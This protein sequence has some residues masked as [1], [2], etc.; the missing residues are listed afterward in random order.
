MK[1]W[2]ALVM[3]LLAACDRAV[4]PAARSSDAVT[5]PRQVE[6]V[7]AL[8]Q[9]ISVTEQLPAELAPW[10]VVAVYPKV[11]GFVANIPVDRGS[12]VRRGELLVKLS[13]PELVA[14]TA[15]A[16]AALGSDRS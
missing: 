8:L 10:E 5:S 14:Q 9:Q 15:E 13:A 11:R 4:T 6:V 7:P 1:R 16:E 12:T 2:L 3:I